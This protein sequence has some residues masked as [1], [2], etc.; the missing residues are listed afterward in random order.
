MALDQG[1]LWTRVCV[2]V[3]MWLLVLPPATA[4]ASEPL[5]RGSCVP[6][7]LR[8]QAREGAVAGGGCS[9]PADVP[10]WRSACVR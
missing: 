7:L 6:G 1:T 8:A 4:A 5:S 10:V 3:N 9:Q 2:L